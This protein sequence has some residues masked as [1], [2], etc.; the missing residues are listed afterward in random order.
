VFREALNIR[1]DDAGWLK[2]R[3]LEAARRVTAAQLGS[4]IWGTYWRLDVAIERQNKSAVVR[5]IWIIRTGEGLP[6][7]VTC[8]VL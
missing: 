8:W 6:M 4:D 7:F 2:D 5:T 3:F 1:R